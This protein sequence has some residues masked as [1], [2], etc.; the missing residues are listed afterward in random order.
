[1]RILLV[2]DEP[3]AARYIAKGLREASFAVDI[4][5]DGEAAGEQC[6]LHDYDAVVLDV[7]L[8]RKDGV[9]LCRELRPGSDVN[10]AREAGGSGLAGTLR[11][12]ES[13]PRGTTFTARLL[14]GE[15]ALA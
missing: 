10:P 9:T 4:A 12:A 7:M 6:A 1:V 3:T 15:D 8:P 2:E 14:H 13:G 11:V 5:A